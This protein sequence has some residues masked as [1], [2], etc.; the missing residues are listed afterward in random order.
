MKKYLITGLL[1][2]L[3]T[4]VFAQKPGWHQKDLAKDSLMG[5]SSERAYSD[6]L[7]HKKSKTVIVG[8]VDV[9]VD[10]LQ[11]DLKEVLWTDR[12]TKVHGWNY[13]GAET[14]R[15]DVTNLARDKKA[16]YD[17]LAY[18][19][20]PEQ[21]RKGYQTYRKVIPQLEHK[22]ADMQALIDELESIKITADHIAKSIG[23]ANPVIADF[24]AYK[25]QNTNEEQLIERII[26][27]LKLYSDWNSYYNDEIIHI[28]ALAKFHLEHGLNTEDNKPDTATGDYNISPDK[29]GP[30]KDPNIGGAYHGTHVAGIIGAI[31][32]NGIGMDGIADNVQIM[33]LKANGTIRELRDKYLAMAIRYAVDHGAKVIN[34]SFGKPYTWDKKAV[35]DAVKYAM[36]KDVLLIHAAGNAGENLDTEEHYPN[37]VYAD[38]SGRANAWIEVGASGPKDDKNLAAPF[39][40]YGKKD[41]DMF[42]P[43]EAIYS[44]LPYNQYQSWDGTSMATPV[45]AGV[46]TLIR[47]YYPRLT[48]VQVKEIMMKTVV[49]REILKEKCV[50]GGVVN[51]YNALKLAATYK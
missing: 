47:E 17:S 11:E 3:Y 28:I 41:V 30:V 35:D 6:L 26:R 24:K 38:K 32:N 34:M 31:R 19:T 12:K 29:L 4:I 40:N 27:R 43:G 18:I 5:I 51:A 10:T 14:G 37:P 36:K 49:K 25:P 16:L 33:M 22:R 44:T 8:I 39:S 42:A 15:E 2:A 48:A 7:K 50:S 46:A 1:A 13:I 20:V 23:K 45:V 21:Y 9:G